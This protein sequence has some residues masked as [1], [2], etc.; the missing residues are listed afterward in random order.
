MDKIHKNQIIIYVI[1]LLLVTAG[2]LNYTEKNTVEVSTAENQN[3]TDENIGDAVL[4]SNNDENENEESNITIV[5]SN[6]N[7]NSDED[8]QEV[9][10]NLNNVDAIDNSQNDYFTNSKLERDKM[11]S[12]M[13]ETYQKILD[14]TSISEEQKSIA[15]QEIKKI[16]DTKNSIMICEN[17]I[18]TKGFENS[19]IFINGDVVDAVIKAEKLSQEQVAQIQ[20]IVTREMNTEPENIH[21]MTK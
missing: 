17:L 9:N 14:N 7:T 19:V 11:Y 13:L 5:S 8:E 15:T 12:Q 21:I 18:S 3:I 20:N 16:N 6:E 10:S 4:V 2:Y 1:A